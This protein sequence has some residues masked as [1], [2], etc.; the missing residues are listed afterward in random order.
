MKADMLKALLENSGMSEVDIRSVVTSSFTFDE[1]A[2]ITSQVQYEA[3]S[4]ALGALEAD[5]QSDEDE[6]SSPKG[7][8]ATALGAKM[9]EWE[10]RHES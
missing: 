10:E 7:H 9:I 8:L 5:F 6:F 1:T 2:E 4:K 3:Y